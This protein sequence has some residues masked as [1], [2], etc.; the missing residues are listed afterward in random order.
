M[1]LGA[2]HRQRRGTAAEILRDGAGFQAAQPNADAGRG[3]TDGLDEID[4]GL[5]VFQVFAPGGDLD[6]RQDDLPISLRLQSGGLLR[7]LIQRQRANRSAGVGDDAVRAEVDAAV[8]H[9][10]HGAGSLAHSAGRQHL[11]HPALEGTV[12]GFDVPLLLHCLLQQIDEAGAV[13]GP[14]DEV[15]VQLANILRMGLGIAA[16]QGRHRLRMVP[17]DTVEHLAGF[18]VADR[19]NGT[20]VDHIGVRRGGKIHHLMS[21]APQLLLHGL[22]L[23]LI[24]FAPEGVNGNFHRGYSLR[25]HGNFYIINKIYVSKKESDFSMIFLLRYY[26]TFNFS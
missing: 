8:L 24:Y 5:A 2:K 3:G 9:L 17:P 18:L 4:Q 25:F 21:P 23:V 12:N 22:G 19:R 15:H 26:Y 11:E 7:R 13:T 10:Q 14:G 16:A 1:E 20:A 6:T